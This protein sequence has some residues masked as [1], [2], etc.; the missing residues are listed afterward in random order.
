MTPLR[1]QAYDS[2]LSDAVVI[3]HSDRKLVRSGASAHRGC[4]TYSLRI[5]RLSLRCVCCIRIVLVQLLA[6][7]GDPFVPGFL[8]NDT[9]NF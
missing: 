7:G 8:C 2:A 9:F 4:L 5:H 6:S 1:V 3:A